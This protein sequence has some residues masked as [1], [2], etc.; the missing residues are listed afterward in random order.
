[1]KTTDLQIGDYIKCQ[2]HIYIVEE[3]SAKGWAH[4]IHLEAK[5]RVNVASRYFDLLEPIPLTPEILELNGCIKTEYGYALYMDNGIVVFLGEDNSYRV[6]IF[7]TTVIIVRYVHELQ[8]VLRL[9]GL[10]DLADN[11]KV[12]D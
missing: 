11:F 7:K 6:I 12:E 5:V 2:G 3:I 9:C 8:Q 10:N 4:L 1:M